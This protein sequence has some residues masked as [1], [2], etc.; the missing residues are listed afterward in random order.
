MICC[1]SLKRILYALGIASFIIGGLLIN[2]FIK[3]HK[4]DAILSV[5]TQIYKI[6]DHHRIPYDIDKHSMDLTADTT[7]QIAQGIDQSIHNIAYFVGKN[8]PITMLLVGFPFKSSNREKKVI[9][10][11]PDMAERK[12]LEYLQAMLNEIKTVYSP[13]A[14][15]LIFCDG[16]PFAELFGIS[17]ATV[18]AYEKALRLLVADL[19]DITLYTSED[20]LKTHKLTS[21]SEIIKFIDQFEPSDKQ[22]RAE[23]KSIPETALKRFILEFDYPQ[24]QLLLKQHTLEDIAIS[25][26]AREMRLRTYLAKEFPSPEFFRLTVH[27]SPDVSKKFGIR[28]SPKSDITPYHGVLVQEADGSWFIRFKKDIDKTKYQL[29]KDLING[30]ECSYFKHI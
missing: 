28:L 11:L 27:F 4:N 15:I 14:S 9:G 26:L 8:R 1:I 21:S 23:L 12:S 30:I 24:G 5:S 19:P 18:I 10:S 22:F 25:L 13:G 2:S 16:I 29:K 7:P 6:L 17:N 3:K 20:M